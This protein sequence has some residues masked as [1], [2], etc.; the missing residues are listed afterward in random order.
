MCG[1]LNASIPIIVVYPMF[2]ILL[3]LRETE[4][5]HNY[6]RFF[7]KHTLKSKHLFIRTKNATLDFMTPSCV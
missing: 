1:L 7:F 5:V 3:F 4:F 2:H 6:K